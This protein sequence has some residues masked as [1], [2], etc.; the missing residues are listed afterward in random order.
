MQPVGRH[1]AGA[2][3]ELRW[4]RTAAP[5]QPHR[6]GHARV[7][8]GILAVAL[9]ACAPAPPPRAPPITTPAP[10]IASAPPAPV[11]RV[12]ARVPPGWFEVPPP[13]QA[14]STCRN[15]IYAEWLVAVAGDEM[16]FTQAVPTEA[17]TGPVLKPDPAGEPRGRR[18][19][20]AAG[21][22]FLV[23]YDA[24][25]W[26]GALYWAPH[27]GAARV[28][29][30]RENVRGLVVLGDTAALSLEGLTH[31][32]RDRGAV[33]WLQRA[34]SGWQ[35]VRIDAL[36]G[37]P[38][39]FVAAPDA[40]YLVTRA[41][42]VRVRRDGRIERVQAFDTVGLFPD[43]MAV[44]GAGQ[45]WVGMRGY[46]ARLTPAGEMYDV[47]WFAPLQCRDTVAASLTE[48]ARATP[49]APSSAAPGTWP[50]AAT[51]R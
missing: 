18:H 44:D 7:L 45:L 36:E 9:T 6:Y 2:I 19:S 22:G 37:S 40:A 31:M 27:D 38:Q 3:A 1:E 48:P 15:D 28:Q 42:L 39:A 26:G 46:V 49:S 13:D 41:S 21:R 24:G 11:S 50:T 17:N 5:I 47:Q 10:V 25:E 12:A 33:R 4:A 32:R 29:I 30:A 23:G 20:I 35:T 8:L 43:S 51:G 14:G 34:G 16:Q